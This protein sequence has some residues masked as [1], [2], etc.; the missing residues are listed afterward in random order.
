MT[1]GSVLRQ[2]KIL[3]LLYVYGI[4]MDKYNDL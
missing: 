4:I 3:R 2:E 1:G